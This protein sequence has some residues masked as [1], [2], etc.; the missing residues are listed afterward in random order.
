MVDEDQTN[1]QS[2]AT[3]HAAQEAGGRSSRGPEYGTGG[4]PQVPVPPYDDLRGEP[5]ENTAPKAFDASNAP[6]PGPDVPV[7]D[8]E[9]HGMSPTDID[10]EPPLGV[11]ISRG[12][13]AED[14]APD[15]DQ[16]TKGAGRPFGRAGDDDSDDRDGPIDPRSPDLQ[17][18]DQGG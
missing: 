10:P 4:E 8:E 2:T 13:R 17:T 3:S 15:H 5:G 16:P 18:G 12:G 14:Q 1:N 9:R 6:E 11:G 7:S